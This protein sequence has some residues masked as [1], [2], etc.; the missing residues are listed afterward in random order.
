MIS[1]SLDHLCEKK[2]VLYLYRLEGKLVASGAS[3]LHPHE[4]DGMDLHHHRESEYCSVQAA[5]SD[6]P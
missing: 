5:S 3:T 1:N 2:S 6:R 4:L